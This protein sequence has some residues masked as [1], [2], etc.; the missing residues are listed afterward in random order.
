MAAKRPAQY[1][2]LYPVLM[3]GCVIWA[4]ACAG[5]I[6]GAA[7]TTR[8]VDAFLMPS[9]AAEARSAI[10]TQG[11]SMWWLL[12]AAAASL[13]FQGLLLLQHLLGEEEPPQKQEQQDR[14][15][16]VSKEK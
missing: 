12:G 4:A 11:L 9:K 16:E 3:V 6:G 1:R 7:H 13:Y 8:I 14:A 10:E 15:T 5:W 2:R